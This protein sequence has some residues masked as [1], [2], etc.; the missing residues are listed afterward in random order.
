MSARK[1]STVLQKLWR[2]C[3]TLPPDKILPYC[4]ACFSSTS[5]RPSWNQIYM[6]KKKKIQGQT[7]FEDLD[8]FLNGICIYWE[9]KVTN[10]LEIVRGNFIGKHKTV[11]LLRSVRN[12][13]LHP[14][15]FV[16]IYCRLWIKY[17][18]CIIHMSLIKTTFKVIGRHKAPIKFP[19][20]ISNVFVTFFS[21]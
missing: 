15:L 10:T 8:L 18:S 14:Y 4:Q 11:R 16:F 20:T 19:L 5:T 13:L 6:S 12:S 1:S 7:L 17:K 21:Q 9:K 2:N 3:N